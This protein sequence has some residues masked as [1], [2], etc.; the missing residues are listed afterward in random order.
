[1]RIPVA[2][3]LQRFR[4]VEVILDQFAFILSLGVL[5]IAVITWL[6]T[7]IVEARL[8]RIDD[9]LPLTV[10]SSCLSAL[11]ISDQLCSHTR[12]EQQQE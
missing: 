9:H 5:E 3:N 11:G 6:I 1:L 4:L 8:V 2:G 12:D 7:I 10:E